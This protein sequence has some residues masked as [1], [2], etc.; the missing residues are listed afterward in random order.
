MAKDV[1]T[2]HCC[3][4]HGCKYGEE[5]TC[6]VVTKEHPQSYRC[7][8]CEQDGI[9]PTK[10]TPE[11]S[12]FAFKEGC[13]YALAE[14]D[15]MNQTLM[16][17]MGRLNNAEGKTYAICDLWMWDMNCFRYVS[18]VQGTDKIMVAQ[19]KEVTKSEYDALKASL[20]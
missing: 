13:Y 17:V 20:K 15:K 11:T 5:D 14:T 6:T 2:E 10:A 8:R 9:D 4:V 7:E 19:W 16:Y 12:I 18:S 3:I 1:H